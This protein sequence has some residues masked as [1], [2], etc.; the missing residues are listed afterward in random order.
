[1][2]DAEI[3]D[4]NNGTHVSQTV[5]RVFSE[6]SNPN[7][8]TNGG[9]RFSK[10]SFDPFGVESDEQKEIWKNAILSLDTPRRALA[11]GT[12]G[13]TKPLSAANVRKLDDITKGFEHLK[14][15]IAKKSLNR[16][17][18]LLR[19]SPRT[20]AKRGLLLSLTCL[21]TRSSICSAT[22]RKTRR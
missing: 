9:V 2:T 18:F 12:S 16:D 21:E 1:M 15:D 22:A 14:R 7:S 11:P 3:E 6:G 10:E 13:I 4:L 8:Q 20:V 17:D 19:I 5:P